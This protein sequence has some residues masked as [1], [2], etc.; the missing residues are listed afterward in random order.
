MLNSHFRR[1]SLRVPELAVLMAERGKVAQPRM[2]GGMERFSLSQDAWRMDRL[3][4][5]SF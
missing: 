4:P 5:L 3:S 2:H 1:E